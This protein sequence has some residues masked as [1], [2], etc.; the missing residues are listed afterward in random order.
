MYVK[1]TK[2]KGKGKDKGS[3]AEGTGKEKGMSAA[4]GKVDAEGGGRSPG[5]GERVLVCP[6]CHGTDIY[7]ETGLMTGY[8]YHCK[9]CDYIG[10]FI[11]QQDI[12]ESD[13]DGPTGKDGK[14]AAKD[15]SDGKD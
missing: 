13:D 7:Y 3:K 8:K 14:R 10:A 2:V 5:P 12:P 11:I 6:Q 1:L 9:R 15:G 4:K